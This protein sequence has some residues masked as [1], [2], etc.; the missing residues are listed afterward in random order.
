MQHP[1]LL[2]CNICPAANHDGSKVAFENL[3]QVLLHEKEEHEG[4]KSG[5]AENERPR[6]Y[7]PPAISDYPY[8]CHFCG[9]DGSDGTGGGNSLV[10]LLDEVS[11][12]NHC[13]ANHP[14]K[15]YYCI[16]CPIDLDGTSP[17]GKFGYRYW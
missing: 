5:M 14:R 10:R 7:N 12:R 8:S 17:E 13:L 4:T 16:K 9:V 11:F 1:K 3:D 15:I 6:K 2:Q